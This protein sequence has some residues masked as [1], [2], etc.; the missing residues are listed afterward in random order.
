MAATNPEVE[1]VSAWRGEN[2][3]GFALMDVRQR[4]REHPNPTLPQGF[5]PLPWMR[6]PDIHPCSI[7]WRTGDGEA[8]LIGVSD[9]WQTLTEAERIEVEMIHPATGPWVGWY[10]PPTT[11][12]PA[13]PWPDPTRRRA[14]ARR[15][16]R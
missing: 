15:G 9:W 5:T 7:G 14:P 6:F 13:R 12:P 4:L 2:L 16:P 3:L 1:R 11:T 8:Y 10:D